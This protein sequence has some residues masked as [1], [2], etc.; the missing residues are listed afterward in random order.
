MHI[1]YVVGGQQREGRPLLAPA[2]WYDYQRGLVLRVDLEQRTVQPALDYVSPPEVRPEGNP[3]VLFKC[4]TLAGDRLYLCTHSEILVYSVPHF[5]QVGYITLP[6]FNDLHHVR[7]TPRGTI[8]AVIT[9]LDMV[10]ELSQQGQTIREWTLQDGEQP[11]QR[12]SKDVDYRKI[13]STKPHQVHPNYVWL[14][15]DDIWVTRFEQKD[16]IS[17][18]GPKRRIDIGVERTHDGVVAGERVYFTSVKGDVIVVNA[19]TLQIE[20][21]VDLNGFHRPGTLLGWCRG[22]MV[23][24]DRVWVGFSHIR[25]TKFRENIGWVA[26]GFRRS[27]PTHIGCYDLFGGGGCVAEIPLEDCGMDAVFS[28]LPTAD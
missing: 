12:F 23:D 20:L 6:A 15:N 13:A 16:A 10:V 8:L 1:A 4:G 25:P 22:L 28:I 19:S 7:P 24:G 27:E 14:L 9:G 18:T 5:E 21:V 2:S 11:W 26:K 17:L 3:P